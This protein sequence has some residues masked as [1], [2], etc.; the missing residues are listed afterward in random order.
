MPVSIA[1]DGPSGAGK[2]TIAQE[3]AKRL[4][5]MYLDT[6]AM[7]RTVGLYMLRKGVALSDRAAVV[8][9]LPDVNVRVAYEGGV[10][11]MYLN[12]EDVSDA[13][14]VH[15]VSAAAS[16]VS[17]IP[18]VRRALVPAQREIASGVD[19]I[20]DGRDIGT[21]VLPNASV[22]VFLTADALVRA[23]RRRGQLLEKK[24]E[25]KL[26]GEVPPVEQIL[27][28]IIRR[29]YNDTHREDSPLAKADDA[30]EID[31]TA[32]D[33]ETCTARIVEMAEA[34]RRKENR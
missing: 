2:S 11:K 16:A 1:L 31:T 28:D 20:M 12:G 4:G 6:G 26:E 14:R 22:K 9:Q 30:V 32:M 25:G 27:E 3:V 17:S 5:A 13:I 34:A 29:D 18:E 15:E 24:A 7:Y 23:Q 21:V 8:A 33:I 19:I 10:Q